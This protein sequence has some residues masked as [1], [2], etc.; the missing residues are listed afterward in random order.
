MNLGLYVALGV[1]RTF[2]APLDISDGA[3]DLATDEAEALRLELDPSTAV[4]VVGASGA[5]TVGVSTL[6]D[7]ETKVSAG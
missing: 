5:D 6:N 7:V 3:F 2:D 1:A 4:D